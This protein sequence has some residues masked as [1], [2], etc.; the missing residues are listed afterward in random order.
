MFQEMKSSSLGSLQISILIFDQRFSKITSSFARES[1]ESM[2]SCKFN[3]RGLFRVLLPGLYGTSIRTGLS[4]LDVP[5]FLDSMVEIENSTRFFYFKLSGKLSQKEN[6]TSVH[7]ALK[8]RLQLDLEIFIE[9]HTSCLMILPTCMSLSRTGRSLVVMFSSTYMDYMVE[10][11]SGNTIDSIERPVVG[12]VVTFL[13]L[14][15]NLY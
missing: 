7:T 9:W 11:A 10:I 14:R 5:N 8:R 6:F 15:S 2:Q 13:T 12:Y 3:F 1:E 4:V